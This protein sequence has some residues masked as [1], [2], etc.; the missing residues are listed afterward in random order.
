MKTDNIE[1]LFTTDPT[2]YT[3]AQRLDILQAL[4]ERLQY[5]QMRLMLVYE[6][7]VAG[8]LLVAGAPVDYLAGILQRDGINVRVKSVAAKILANLE[9]SPAQKSAFATGALQLIDLAENGYYAAAVVEIL[10]NNRSG[11]RP[12]VMALTLHQYAHTN[13]DFRSA[14]YELIRAHDLADAFYTFG[15]KGI[16]QLISHNRLVSHHGS[17]YALEDFLVSTGQFN[18]LVTLFHTMSSKEWLQF[19]RHAERKKR[20]MHKICSKAAEF[21]QTDTTIIFPVLDFVKSLGR[22]F[23]PEEYS[24]VDV[25]FEQTGSSWL[26]V[27]ILSK[28]ILLDNDWEFASFITE[29]SFDYLLFEYEEGVLGDKAAWSIIHGLDYR[30]ETAL[31]T[32]LRALFDAAS[33]GTFMAPPPDALW[34]SQASF[35][36]EREA[37]DVRYFCS[38]DAFREG[39]QRYYAAFG[40]RALNEDELYIG[41]DQR[42]DRQKAA[43]QLVFR[44]LLS[45][46]N[47]CRKVYLQCALKVLGGEGYFDYFR[48]VE[49]LDFRFRSETDRLRVTAVIRDYYAGSLQAVDFTNVYTEKRMPDGQ[50]QTTW[51]RRE[52]LLG[53]LLEKY[54]FDTP[55]SILKKMVWLDQGGIRNFSAGKADNKGSVT[56]VILEMLPETE[57][58]LFSEEVL[59]NLRSGIFSD[60]VKGNHAGLCRH[61]HIAEARHLIAGY[62]LADDIRFG[63]ADYLD[64]FIELGGDEQEMLPL[65]GKWNQGYMHEYFHLVDKLM[66]EHRDIVCQSLRSVLEND[67]KEESTRVQA[68]LCLSEQGDGQ[69]F[70]FLAELV[71]NRKVSPFRIQ[72]HRSVRAVDTAFA[73]AALGGLA[74]LL[75]ETDRDVHFAESPKNIVLE[76]LNTF[77][78]KSGADAM[79]VYH[80]L[81]EQEVLLRQTHELHY[82]LYWY[83]LH[84]LERFRENDN[85][86][87]GNPAIKKVIEAY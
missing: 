78:A 65:L 72:G 58:A 83:A 84:V 87:T 73:L 32:A 26:A 7:S 38:I 59:D 30:G 2:K 35:E 60:G 16:N 76:W 5:Y 3:A 4:I 67:Q 75:A 81:L 6:T 42:P 25:F 21:Y 13:H 86:V 54:R 24:E 10:T 46:A 37:N 44:F 51:R 28:E 33:G 27:R 68:A 23:L 82:D 47:N 70:L 49:F 50:V 48:A 22:K 52:V 79:L 29:S 36:E 55:P 85:A 20:F 56:Q 66:K 61:L 77:G 63:H 18:N 19:Y 62:L 11:D 40:K 43:S 34:L 64:I 9:F 8:F 12:L 17:E 69:A 74:H 39:V 53:R 1:L 41:D 31:S 15:L 14:V 57:F 71:G 80:F 45:L